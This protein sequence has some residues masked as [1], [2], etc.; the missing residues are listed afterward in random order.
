LSN[1]TKQQNELQSNKTK[2]SRGNLQ[3]SKTMVAKQNRG[4]VGKVYVN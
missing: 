4:D 2:L 1:T 3:S